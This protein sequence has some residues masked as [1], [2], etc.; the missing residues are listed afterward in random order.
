MPAQPPTN[1]EATTDGITTPT[2]PVCSTPLPIAGAPCPR[3]STSRFAW[4]RS[5]TV[6]LSLC[7]LLLI[8]MFTTTGVI[9]RLFHVKEAKIAND[10]EKAGNTNLQAGRADVA[11]EDFRNALLYSSDSNQLQLELA[12]A[13]AAQGQLDEAEDYLFNL[14][15]GD[16]ENSPIDL[17]LARIAARQG[18][19][20]TAVGFYHDAAFGQWPSNAHTNRVAARE[21]LIAFLLKHNRE[22]QARAEALSLAADNPADPDIRVAAAKSLSQAGDAQSAFDEYRHILRIS[23]ENTEALLGAGQTALAL[24]NFPEADRYFSR[25]IQRGVKAPDVAAQRDLAAAAAELN[26]FDPR[27]SEKE[28]QQRILEIF[29]AAEERAKAC[30]PVVLS[31]GPAVPDDLKALAAE[32]AALPQKLSLAVFNAH[33]EYAT[34]ALNWAFSLEGA[35]PSQCA[36]TLA[37]RAIG[38]LAAENKQS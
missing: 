1:P 12:E 26:P 5:R 23:P 32:R 3:C 20:E 14:R 9:V 10:W 33:P 18:D 11:I 19:V 7:G 2:C 4:G 6:F 8:P 21:E 24:Y 27:L 35:V 28:R 38:V 36:G 17:A 29:S 31:G 13:L 34:Q 37:D 16:P 15:T 25:A 22:D 30:I